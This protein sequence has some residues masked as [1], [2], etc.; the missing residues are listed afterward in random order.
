MSNPDSSLDLFEHYEHQSKALKA[1]TEKFSAQIE[2]SEG[3]SY[4]VLKQFHYE[5]QQLGYTFD[6]GL[7]A[8][9]YNF[10]QDVSLLDESVMHRES[11]IEHVKM[12]CPQGELDEIMNTVED[13]SLEDI[14][15]LAERFESGEPSG[16]RPG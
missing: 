6:Y 1:I 14:S 13:M 15:E 2:E 16:P 7:D 11:L 10:R 5:V 3:D 4:E 12:V 8:V 9:P